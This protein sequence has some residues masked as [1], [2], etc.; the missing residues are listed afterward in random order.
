MQLQ[1]PRPDSGQQGNEERQTD[2]HI[3]RKLGLGNLS[4]QVEKPQ[5]PRSS[6]FIIYREWGYC[7]QL[8]KE[9]GLLHTDKQGGMVYGIQL[10]QR[11][12]FS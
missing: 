5:H 7:I 11:D 12:K 2:G 1:E 6:V 8:N 9:T 10:E 3:K 4:S